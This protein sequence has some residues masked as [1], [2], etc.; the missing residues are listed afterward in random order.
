MDNEKQE[1]KQEEPIIKKVEVGIFGK[2]KKQLKK[3]VKIEENKMAG[4]KS[5]G[6]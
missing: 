6:K 5:G 3:I 2:N 1:I 4:K